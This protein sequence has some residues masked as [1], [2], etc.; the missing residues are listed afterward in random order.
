[1]Q[2]DSIHG[3][4]YVSEDAKLIVNARVTSD[5]DKLGNVIRSAVESVK[6]TYPM[7]ITDS[8][9]SC[10]SPKPETPTFITL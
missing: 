9:E 1:M 7:E 4:R 6:N 2:T 8:S 3:S 10:Y 5:P